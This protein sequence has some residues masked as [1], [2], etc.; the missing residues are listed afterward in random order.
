MFVNWGSEMRTTLRRELDHAA[1]RDAMLLHAANHRHYDYGYLTVQSRI[2]ED[3][4]RESR[5]FSFHSA[6]NCWSL[7]GREI[8]Q[9]FHQGMWVAA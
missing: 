8:S 6:A 7:D 5:R 9:V 3:T 4:T 2:P 1:R